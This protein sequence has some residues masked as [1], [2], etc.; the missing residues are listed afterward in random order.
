MLLGILVVSLGKA[1]FGL[2][3]DTGQLVSATMICLPKVLA[4]LFMLDLRE[5]RVAALL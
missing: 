5:E 4:M 3:Q 1:N 2:G